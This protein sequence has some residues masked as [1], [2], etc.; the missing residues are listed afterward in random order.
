[1][2]IHAP[3]LLSDSGGTTT[4]VCCPRSLGG[5]PPARPP[6]P[7]AKARPPWRHCH[8][9]AARRPLLPTPRRQWAEWK[10]PAEAKCTLGNSN[11]SFL[12]SVVS[13]LQ[14]F[15]GRARASEGAAAQAQASEVAAAWRE[16]YNLQRGCGRALRRSAGAV[17]WSRGDGEGVRHRA[18]GESLT[19]P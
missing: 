11:S 7:P 4:G 12:P 1:M 13:T 14:H 5:P 9:C 2:W 10:L 19:T 16:G 6:A 8:E 17:A 18:T 15:A 3:Y